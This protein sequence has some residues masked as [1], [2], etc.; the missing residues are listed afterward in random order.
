MTDNGTV[1]CDALKPSQHDLRQTG[2]SLERVVAIRD[3]FNIPALLDSVSI[4][5]DIYRLIRTARAEMQIQDWELAALWAVI[6]LGA[7]L[8]KG[9]EK[10]VEPITYL[11]AAGPAGEINEVSSGTKRW[12]AH[13]IAGQERIRANPVW[14]PTLADRFRAELQDNLSRQDLTDPE[15]LLLLKAMS[16]VSSEWMSVRS[17]AKGTGKSHGTAQQLRRILAEGKPELFDLLRAGHL[18]SIN[19]AY[20]AL[21]KPPVIEESQEWF[22]KSF[23]DVDIQPGEDE[24]VLVMLSDIANALASKSVLAEDC[25]PALFHEAQECLDEVRSLLTAQ[26]SIFRKTGRLHQD[27]IQYIVDRVM[28]CQKRCYDQIQNTIDSA[29]LEREQEQSSERLGVASNLE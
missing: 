19:A 18:T 11:K 14:Y 16:D 22:A 25:D 10:L 4:P 7:T 12:L 23:I 24:F 9:S 1:R 2:L 26:R 13:I 21:D 6:E 28:Y 3:R 5:L 27:I 8:A 17:I 15:L 29:M 20:S